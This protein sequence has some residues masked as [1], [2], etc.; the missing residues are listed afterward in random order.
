VHSAT[1]AGGIAVGAVAD[2]VIQPWGAMVIGT[3]TGIISVLAFQFIT[4][5][6][7][8]GAHDTR[9]FKGIRFIFIGFI[10]S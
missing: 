1:L 3:A 9:K 10:R 2:M 6:L 8:T 5:L 7:N 4:P